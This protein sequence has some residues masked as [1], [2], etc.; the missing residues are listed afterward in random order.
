MPGQNAVFAF[1]SD[2]SS[3]EPLPEKVKARAVAALSPGQ[4]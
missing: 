3:Y 1:M 4:S 2:P